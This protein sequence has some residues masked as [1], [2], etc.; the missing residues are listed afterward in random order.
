VV[1]KLERI[2]VQEKGYKVKNFAEICQYV[3]KL[4]LEL[5]KR[6]LSP[7]FCDLQ[8]NESLKYCL[9][10]QGYHKFCHHHW[11]PEEARAV[12]LQNRFKGNNTGLLLWGERGCGKSH[13][14]SYAVAW[15]HENNWV[16]LTVPS[17][18]KFIHHDM[19]IFRW[20]NGLYLQKELAKEMLVDFAISNEQVLREWEVDQSLYG[21]YDLS[22][23]KDTEFEPC[24]RF[25]D[26]KHQCWS[27]SWKEKLYDVEINYYD[28]QYDLLAF[29]LAS[30]DKLPEPRYISDIVNFGIANPELATNAVAE[31]LEQ[32]YHTDKY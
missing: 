3:P 28:Q 19:D 8:Q 21:Q 23:I 25:W 32:L 9:Y 15:A 18:E 4:D 16:N 26:E 27:D 10:L 13:V 5:E 14:L 12:T 11:R 1:D 30:P 31:L 20:K 17:A 2:L 22:G 7:E 6:D 29:R 24:P